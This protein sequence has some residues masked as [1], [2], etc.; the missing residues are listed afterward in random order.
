MHW[1]TWFLQPPQHLSILGNSHFHHMYLCHIQ[2]ICYYK[3]S[4]HRLDHRCRELYLRSSSFHHSI[5]Q[6]LFYPDI[7]VHSEKYSGIGMHRKSQLMS[8]WRIVCS[9]HLRK[10]NRQQQPVGGP[11]LRLLINKSLIF[12]C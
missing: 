11:T 2:N 1:M 9:N 6:L 5:M 12:C 8:L 3:T 10:M 7:V 4:L